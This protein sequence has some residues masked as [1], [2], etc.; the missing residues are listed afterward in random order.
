MNASKTIKTLMTDKG[1][2]QKDMQ[3]KLDMKSQSGVGQALNRDMRI[4]M[5][6]RFLNVLNCDLIIRDKD[7]TQEWIVD[8]D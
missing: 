1:I 2:A 7:T 4:S 5:L 3:S 6:I 8:S